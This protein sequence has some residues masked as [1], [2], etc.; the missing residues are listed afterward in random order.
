MGK[1]N[2]V[3]EGHEQKKRPPNGSLLLA[4]C[5]LMLALANTQFAPV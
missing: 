1:G 5:Q 4:D 2:G 3:D